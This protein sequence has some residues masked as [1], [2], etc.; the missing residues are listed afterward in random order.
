MSDVFDLSSI[1]PVTPP[2]KPEEKAT[3][4]FYG[5]PGVGKTTLAGSA[6]KVESMAPVLLMDFENGSSALARKYPDVDVVQIPDWQTALAVLDALV[7]ENTKYRTVI[8]DTVG[9]AQEQIL[10]W[11]E[12]VFRKGETNS[13][14]KWAD[15]AE[16]MSKVIKLLHQSDM[17]VIVLGHAE[18]DR[19]E[20][21]NAKTVRPE[22]QG[23]KSHT[24]LPKIFDV[25]GY[26][27]RVVGKDEQVHRVLQFEPEDDTVAKDRNGLFPDHVVDPDFSKLYQLVVEGLEDDES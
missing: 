23:R 22:F 14:A 8:F 4:L 9:T 27:Q 3:Y 19:D 24:A 26:L 6:A 17:N 12:E 25:I 16:Q 5:L 15:V 13:Y 21:T 18:R 7:N 11:S 1:A 2:R 20:F 10:V